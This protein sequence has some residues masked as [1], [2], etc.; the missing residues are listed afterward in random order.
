MAQEDVFW[1]DFWI[2]VELHPYG[3]LKLLGLMLQDYDWLADEQIRSLPSRTLV[4][5]LLQTH[6]VE[7]EFSEQEIASWSDDHVQHIAVAWWNEQ[8][9]DL[10][11]EPLPESSSFDLI[12]AGLLHLYEQKIAPQQNRLRDFLS[13][14]QRLLSGLTGVAISLPSFN[15]IFPASDSG[16]TSRLAGI[17]LPAQEL[18]QF[19]D[20]S[21]RLQ[22]FYQ[23]IMKSTNILNTQAFSLASQ[24]EQI[25][26]PLLDPSAFF[27]AL[28]DLS[29][30]KRF[31]EQAQQ[32]QKE[33]AIFDESGYSFIGHLI[34]ARVVSHFALYPER[35]RAANIAP[36]A[37]PLSPQ[38]WRQQPSS[39]AE[40]IYEAH[41]AER[42]DRYRQMAALRGLGMT[43]TEI[44]RRIG[45]SPYK[46]RAWLKAG[47][48]PIHRRPHGHRSLFDPYA[49]FVLEQW[50]AGI[51][52]SKQLYAE[53]RQQ[54]YAGSLRLVR[55]F[56]Q[57][58][59]EQRR[60]PEEIVPPS[61]VEQFSAHNAVWLFIRDPKK[62]T[63]QQQEQLAFIRESLASTETAYGLV[64]DFLTMVH[65]RE[66]ERLDAWI[67]AV[68][69]SQIPELQR[70]VTGILA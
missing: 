41:Q 38:V 46:V 31:F 44:A 53:I 67:E 7:P 13:S 8:A 52:D 19:A 68:Q 51:H 6:V 69:A 1:E 37:L 24:L 14:Q 22:G 36:V 18:Q 63:A 60:K 70:F 16:L 55:A 49:A 26:I 3:R 4:I 12:K 65:N 47:A 66:G 34:S 30:L 15:P 50:Q 45:V 39:R 57:P 43:H 42:E 27:G 62:L 35:V 11:L 21:S 25:K 10:A 33:H 58:L 23:Q 32:A 61:S 9:Q 56:L 28:P 64:Q 2:E 59:R 29:Q 54:G 5:Q 40:H 17:R 48:T 20:M